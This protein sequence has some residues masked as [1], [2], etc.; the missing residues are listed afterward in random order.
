[1]LRSTSTGR[2]LIPFLT[3]QGWCGPA[4]IAV[5]MWALFGV[6]GRAAADKLVVPEAAERSQTIIVTYEFEVPATGR[7]FLDI[8]WKDAVGRVVIRQHLPL[9]LANAPKVAFSLDLGRAVTTK[10][11]LAVH[12]SLDRAEQAGAP[13]HYE[14]AAT[15]SFIASPTARPWSD[16]QIIMWQLQTAPGYAA[17]KR[18]GITAGMVEVDRNDASSIRVTDNLDALLSNDLPW[19]VENIA[20]DFYSS[21]HRWSRDRPVNWRFLETKQRYW[22]NPVDIAALSRVPSLSDPDWLNAI[23]GRLR[24]DVRELRR[25]RPLYYNLGDE[26][27][28]AD[29]TA[30]WDFDFSDPSLAAF[31]HW[32]QERYRTM[33]SLNEEWGTEFTAWN[34]VMPLTTRQIM[35]HADD[36][37][38]AWADFKEFMDAAFA[39]AIKTGTDAVHAADP[40][41]LSAI[42]GA[43]IPG[44]G[45]YD[46]SRLSDSVD[47]MELGDYGDNIEIVRS[48]NPALVM[49]TT[50]F[51]RGPR[52]A[53]PVWRE[54]LRGTRGLILWDE[55]REFVGSDDSVGER[56]REA[57]PYFAEIRGGLGALLINSRRRVDPIGVLY[58]PASQRVQ[59]MLDNKA[60]GEQW[61]RR[62][63]SDEYGD[64]AIRIATRNYARAIEHMGLQH[65]FV[66]PAQL[67]T[68][69]LR[70]GAC[71]ILI[72]PHT[73]ALSAA[74]AGEMR[75]FVARGGIIVADGEPGIFDEHGRK[76]SVSPLSDVF[77][78]SS[79]NSRDGLP[80]GNG[81]A[82]ILSLPNGPSRPESQRLA[83]ILEAAGIRPA[84]AV[85]GTGGAAIGD[86]E[87]YVFENGGAVILA[88]QRDLAATPSGSESD[89]AN[90]EAISVTLPHRFHVYDLR[91][92]TVL[93]ETDRLQFEL[94]PIEPILLALSD[95]PLP[96]PAL[97]GP[98]SAHVGE[99]A[100]FVVHSGL[101]STAARAVVRLDVIDPEGNLVPHYSG[102]V[103]ALSGTGSVHLP[104]AVNDKTGVW[105]IRATDVISGETATAE[106]SLEP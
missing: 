28:I 95:K 62:S 91:A 73:I 33:A 8:E 52:E 60:A 25:Y 27:G 20:T 19:Y 5:L 76:L 90:P 72:L 22:A 10:N 23:E 68:G 3:T 32:L 88:M 48:L 46:Y 11:E 43:Q 83:E 86:V 6:G 54:L 53:H 93:G 77:S 64:D 92:R 65:R 1:M 56:G 94:G 59:W 104:F 66:S 40:Q 30:V 55:K 75:N 36:N 7:G 47:V 102:N 21:Y 96:A 84:F 34:Q 26:T 78:G 81:H 89:T 42:E 105:Q 67:T 71:R 103:I 38:A 50:S 35:R 45:G 57:A 99:N 2:Y 39:R 9:D 49:L 31:R 13:L 15:G 58:S 14:N 37:F 80:P 17:L 16:Y 82:I 12:L 61:T 24:Q 106:L 69:A 51:G 101:D 74:E 41:A 18:L 63:A 29:L 85:V 79:R 100:E 70:N 98:Q 44:W 4:G 97:S 87:T